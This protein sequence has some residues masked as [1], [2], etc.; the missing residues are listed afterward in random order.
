M[1]AAGLG[2]THRA[3]AQLPAKLFV[4]QNPYLIKESIE[5]FPARQHEFNSF[6]TMACRDDPVLS[7]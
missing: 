5:G 2:V 3:V 4:R 7:I 1:F 6:T